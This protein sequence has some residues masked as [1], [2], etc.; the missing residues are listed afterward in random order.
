MVDSPS[1]LSMSVK[2]DDS[3]SFIEY[4]PMRPRTSSDSFNYRPRT[5]SFGKLPATCRPRS[6]SHGQGTRPFTN[7]AKLLEQ[8]R[9]SQDPMQRLSRESSLHGSFDSLRISNES[10]RRMSQD[11]RYSPVVNEQ[12]MRDSPPLIGKSSKNGSYFNMD[13]SSSTHRKSSPH[14]VRTES[15]GSGRHSDKTDSLLHSQDNNDYTEMAP[16]SSR[17]H[18][19]DGYMNMGFNG[20]GRQAFSGGSGLSTSLQSSDSTYMN[21]EP[22]GDA[23]SKAGDVRSISVEN[24]DSYVTYD[25]APMSSNKPRAGSL[26]SK[27]KKH[28]HGLKKSSTSSPSTHHHPTVSASTRKGGSSDSLRKTA[29]QS[30]M[31]KYGS[32]GKDFRKKSGST[33][34]RPTSKSGDYQT[35]SSMI[36]FRNPPAHVGK[37]EPADEYIEFSPSA[38]LT[39]TETMFSGVLG[40]PNAHPHYGGSSTVHCGLMNVHHS[41]ANVNAY[42]HPAF[43]PVDDSAYT[44]YSPGIP[45]TVE[46]DDDSSYMPFS[47]APHS[48]SRSPQSLPHRS[49]VAI[50]SA[51]SSFS[52]FQQ[53]QAKQISAK[54]MPD[55]VGFDSSPSHRTSL[56]S[57]S[58]MHPISAV[59]YIVSDAKMGSNPKLKNIKS[60]Y[61]SLDSSKHLM[62]HDP[63]SAIQGSSISMS[64]SLT[65]DPPSY[66]SSLDFPH[67]TQPLTIPPLPSSFSSSSSSFSSSHKPQDTT[68][69]SKRNSSST[70]PP[71]PVDDSEY[72]TCAPASVAKEVNTVA[73]QP[74]PTVSFISGNNSAKSDSGSYSSSTSNSKEP[75]PNKFH[76]DTNEDKVKNRNKASS[77]SKSDT[78]FKSIP[79]CS[80]SQS[81]E[82]GKVQEKQV[83]QQQKQPNYVQ[84]QPGGGL[85]IDSN[86]PTTASQ[87]DSKMS[88]SHQQQSPM[89]SAQVSE[90]VPPL[91]TSRQKH[92]SGSSTSSH[93]SRKISG[94]SDKSL[95]K[96]SKSDSNSSLSSSG[97]GRSKRRAPSGEKS[98]GENSDKGPMSPTKM[99]EF[100]WSGPCA[101][102]LEGKMV[103]VEAK[104]RHSLGDVTGT[105]DGAANKNSSSG[106][107]LPESTPCIQNLES[108]AKD[109]L[110]NKSVAIGTP[111][112]STQKSGQESNTS[113]SRH[114]LSDLGT[115]Q[116]PGTGSSSSSCGPRSNANSSIGGGG[117]MSTI[118]DN[119]A[120]EHKKVLNYAQL[121][122]STP[123]DS[124]G[125]DGK[126]AKGKL[127]SS[128]DA[129]NKQPSLSYAKI[130]FEKC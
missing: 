121:D 127:K 6:S 29:R 72:I 126:G 40:S 76:C 31:E 8:A 38:I 74:F 34:T 11:S 16:I 100:S 58:G 50:P 89:Q 99:D 21:M 92:S 94:D 111:S 106:L 63:K 87:P 37:D 93:K 57:P 14:R 117:A 65:F 1:P 47:P 19:G 84:K 114:S 80:S 122:L 55:Y 78:G 67:P 20:G 62:K 91:N 3:D 70:K 22:T 48:M 32:L 60:Q 88:P 116:P 26:G 98:P 54:E 9:I 13:M 2:S 45:Q 82:S 104:I 52:P 73:M 129:E 105:S 15:M 4:M 118:S 35:T 102:K 33:G 75:S 95:K 46:N 125:G 64:T 69:S 108:S 61:S 124:E 86:C 59:S 107:V 12:E 27:D 44:P 5:S 120:E 101:G 103:Q 68:S 18:D 66:L 97:G 42:S 128:S 10:L 53:T 17:S 39:D 90:N 51:P 123:A 28:T 24:V 115:Y 23:K 112:S 79:T 41:S 36:P 77:T 7:K 71:V 113:G 30:S 109:D 43:Q 96:G 49:H 56:L 81:E 85:V 25:P 110:G 119:V 83:L 130:D